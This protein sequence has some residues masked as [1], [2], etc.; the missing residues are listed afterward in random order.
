MGSEM[1]IRDRSSA[2]QS[3]VGLTEPVPALLIWR[4]TAQDYVSL[5]V[6][7]VQWQGK[8]KL[9]KEMKITKYQA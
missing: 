1:C 2:V 6:M 5:S 9:E 7:I 4:G 8:L 3:R